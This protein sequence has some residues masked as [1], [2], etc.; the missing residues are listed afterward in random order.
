MKIQRVPKAGR[1]QHRLWGGVTSWDSRSVC[2]RK[3]NVAAS[4]VKFLLKKPPAHQWFHPVPGHVVTGSVCE[5]VLL[6]ISQRPHKWLC[7]KRREV[8]VTW[9]TLGQ[10]PSSG[11]RNLPLHRKKRAGLV[12]WVFPD[13]TEPVDRFDAISVNSPGERC[14]KEK[15]IFNGLCQK[16]FLVC[17]T[18]SAEG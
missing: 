2:K 13:L 15:V 6:W 8:A 12:C 16:I 18:L 1:H 14:W 9:H 3:L 7:A 11:R 4:H 17:Q 10:C 5:H